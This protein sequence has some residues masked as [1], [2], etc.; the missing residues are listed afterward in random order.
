MFKIVYR[1]TTF[2]TWV[3]NLQPKVKESIWIL[4]VEFCKNSWVLAIFKCYKVKTLYD[5][6]KYLRESILILEILLIRI[7]ARMDSRILAKLLTLKT[8][9]DLE[10]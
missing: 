1:D 8:E 3:R 9:W 7:F 5:K 2:K 6:R 10:F 4:T